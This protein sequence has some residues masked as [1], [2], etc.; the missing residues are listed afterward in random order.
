MKIVDNFDTFLDSIYT[1]SS[2]N[3][4]RSNDHRKRRDVAGNSS[5]LD[6]SM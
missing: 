6:K 2:D 4:D 5:F 1:P 3:W